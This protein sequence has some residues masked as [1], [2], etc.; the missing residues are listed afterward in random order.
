M[1]G[2][3]VPQA[4]EWREAQAPP[5]CRGA[6]D[7]LRAPPGQPAT[8]MGGAGLVA[9]TC[10]EWC[11]QAWHKGQAGACRDVALSGSSQVRHDKAMGLHPQPTLV[12]LLLR[13]CCQQQPVGREAKR[14]QAAATGRPRSRT[15]IMAWSSQ[16]RLGPATE[17]R[18]PSFHP[19]GSRPGGRCR[20]PHF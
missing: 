17:T 19:F 3:S 2:L 8:S 14:V 20:R 16:R 15:H 1:A 10:E 7:L 9:P 11:F 18:C 13:K 12:L 4:D 6:S 5:S